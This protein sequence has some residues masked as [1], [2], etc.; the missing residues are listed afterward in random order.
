MS[1][2]YYIK[3]IDALIANIF[4]KKKKKKKKKILLANPPLAR[5]PRRA[6]PPLPHQ[7]FCPKPRAW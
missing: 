3:K 2:I 4:I 6:L 5:A 7:D 1:A